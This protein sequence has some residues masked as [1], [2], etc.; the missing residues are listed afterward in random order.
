MRHPRLHRSYR[1]VPS[2]ISL[3]ASLFPGIV[4]LPEPFRDRRVIPDAAFIMHRGGEIGG[5][6]GGTDIRV[7]VERAELLLGLGDDRAGLSGGGQ[8]GGE[9]VFTGHGAFSPTVLPNETSAAAAT[10]SDD[11]NRSE[12]GTLSA[13]ANANR[14][15]MRTPSRLLA[16]S[17]S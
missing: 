2:P 15:P 16:F 8:D 1:V 11:G 14:V 5:A 3:G 12:I 4:G 13:I 7:A 10:S 17:I 6:A 9:A